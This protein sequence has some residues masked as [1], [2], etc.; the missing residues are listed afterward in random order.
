MGVVVESKEQAELLEIVTYGFAAHQRAHHIEEVGVRNVPHPR[1]HPPA[2]GGVHEFNKLFVERAWAGHGPVSWT[3][4]APGKSADF[5]GLK[6][7]P[8]PVVRS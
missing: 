3:G 5:P 6:G 4:R 8:L 1:G 7:N 2:E